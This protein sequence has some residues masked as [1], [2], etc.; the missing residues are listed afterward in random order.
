M[1]FA[2]I[3]TGGKQYRVAEGQE[4]TIEKLA[5]VAS[6]GEKVVFDKVLLWDDGKELRVGDP[7]LAGVTV[8][9]ELTEAGK[10]KKLYIRKF[11]AKSNRSRKIGHRQPYHKVKVAAV[12]A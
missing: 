4:I 1:A 12:K 6:V 3:E 5:G 10:G 8:E 9:A 7:Y 2:I 11:K